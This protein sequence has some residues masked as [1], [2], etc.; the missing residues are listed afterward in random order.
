MNDEDKKKLDDWAKTALPL[1]ESNGYLESEELSRNN[2]FEV[3]A[4]FFFIT[5]LVMAGFLVYMVY[6]GKF[7]S[8]TSISQPIDI[9]ANSTVNNAYSNTFN[10]NTEN[11]YNVNLNVTIIQNIKVNST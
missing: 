6:D 9:N 2:V 5:T 3:L 8:S 7:Q 11:K 1:L 10:P 4:V